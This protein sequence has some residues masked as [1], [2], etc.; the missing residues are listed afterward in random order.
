[1]AEHLHLVGPRQLDHRDIAGGRHDRLAGDVSAVED[2]VGLG[3]SDVAVAA[4]ILLLEVDHVDEHIV[5]DRASTIGILLPSAFQFPAPESK[6]RVLGI[7]D[8][9][10]AEYPIGQREGRV[11][12]VEVPHHEF[13]ARHF[14]TPPDPP[15]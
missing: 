10:F 9:T 13:I 5:H 7:A 8:D 15:L 3:P 1:M 11:K 2:D 6:Y 12:P 14:G 4:E